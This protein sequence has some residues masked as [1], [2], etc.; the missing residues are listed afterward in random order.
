MTDR[1]TGTIKWFDVRK[2]FGFIKRDTGDDLFMHH[3]ALNGFGY[4]IPDEG[5]RVSFTVS[6]GAKGAYADDV[7][8]S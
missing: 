5:M 4:E 8:R 3:S 6:T 7:R 1:E 2:G